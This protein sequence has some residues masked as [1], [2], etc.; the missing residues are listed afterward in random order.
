M[1]IPVYSAINQFAALNGWN[2]QQCTGTAC[3]NTGA[4]LVSVL[5]HG[6]QIGYQSL[7]NMRPVPG[8]VPTQSKYAPGGGTPGLI[9]RGFS[10]DTDNL[11][12]FQAT[13]LWD[14]EVISQVYDS[15]LNL[16]P[17]TGGSNAQLVDWMTTS[18]SSSFNPNEVSCRG[19]VCVTGTTT[20]TWRLRND[21]YFHDGTPVTAN[22][23][24][25]TILAYRDIPSAN[26]GPNVANVATAV[27]LDCATGL[28]CRTLQVKLQNQ[29]PFYELNIGSLPIIPMHVWAP[30]CGTPPNSASQCGNP[31]FDPMASGLFIG[32]GP[33]VCKNVN[34]GTVGGSCT[35][36][37]DGS[38]GTQFLST[39]GKLLLTANTNYMRG[40]TNLQGSSLQKFSWAD[41]TDDG[42]VNILDL[43]DAA[44]H[45]GA[46][47][48]YWV[49][50]T[51]S[52]GSTVNVQDLATVAFYFG[53]GL[54]TPFLPSQLISLDPKID[55]YRVDLTSTGGSVMYY[56]GG[57]PSGGL[58]TV[59][60][61]S[62]TA[63]PNP[64]SL[65][66]TLVCPTGTVIGTASGTTGISSAIVLLG[67][68]GLTAGTLYTLNV[69]YSGN[70]QPIYNIQIQAYP[71]IG[72][73]VAEF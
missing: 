51:I 38:L 73:Q 9:R 33:W 2:Y 36:N 44:S 69:S 53:H 61:V 25:Y 27:G 7:L 46:F 29:S 3:A 62:L 68:S 5:G 22:D 66:G 65:P 10:Q 1:T 58:V 17:L 45:F 52:S 23:V 47:D 28:P 39:G 42:V 54:T 24:A 41:K 49:N 12:P 55:P 14:F 6:F 31:T 8:Y 63:A 32:S 18:H 19:T 50:P 57:L 56:E 37:A 34:T 59:K 15:M 4:S 48:P 40:P 71:P 60:L 20:Q 67:F 16:N 26:L 13:T 70:T 35:Q 43:A 72:G 64:A 30:I 21:V 11:S